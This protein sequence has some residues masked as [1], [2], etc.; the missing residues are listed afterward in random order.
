[1]RN[2]GPYPT[3]FWDASFRLVTHN[4]V[5]AA[6][7]GLNVLVE[8]R[9]DSAAERVMFVVPNT[10][11]PRALRIDFRGESTELPLRLL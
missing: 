10:S 4:A 7:G 5:I 6:S 8:G 11:V 2:P 9:S 3:N 1:M